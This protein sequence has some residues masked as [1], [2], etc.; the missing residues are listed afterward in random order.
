MS[1]SFGP[2]VLLVFIASIIVDRYFHATPSLDPIVI[3]DIFCQE[4]SGE[5]TIGAPAHEMTTVASMLPSASS[6]GP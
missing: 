1:F 2:I 3:I 6:I 4:P 5:G